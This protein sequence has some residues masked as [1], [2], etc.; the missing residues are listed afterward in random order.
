MKSQLQ[1][2]CKPDEG[3]SRAAAHRARA[4]APLAGEC[5]QVYRGA[6]QRLAGSPATE[7]AAVQLLRCGP[8]GMV[9]TARP[10]VGGARFAQSLRLIFTDAWV[11]LRLS[12]MRT[13]ASTH[14]NTH[15]HTHTHTHTRTTCTHTHTQTHA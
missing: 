7:Q 5:Y 12:G 15:T 13:G 4:H 6:A 9:H 1:G 14:A 3:E 8:C 2:R 11:L 10:R